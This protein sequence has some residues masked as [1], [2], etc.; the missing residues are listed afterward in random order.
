[1]EQLNKVYLQNIGKEVYIF[2]KPLLIVLG[3]SFCTG[4]CI[5]FYG[6]ICGIHLNNPSSWGSSIFLIGTPICTRFA[7]LIAWLHDLVTNSWLCVGAIMFA[8]T[9]KYLPDNLTNILEKK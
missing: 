6:N 8:S 3:I 4:L 1:M 2:F 9:L 7:S 5:S